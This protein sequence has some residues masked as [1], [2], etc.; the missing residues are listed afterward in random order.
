MEDSF[1]ALYR[2]LLARVEPD[3]ARLRQNES[4]LFSAAGPGRTK[5]PLQSEEKCAIEYTE[6]T[7]NEN[8]SQ[9]SEE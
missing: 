6:T 4:A 2:G 8:N 1:A 3:P 7:P 9:G 5:T